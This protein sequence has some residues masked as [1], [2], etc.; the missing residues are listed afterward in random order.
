MS[1]QEAAS[2]EKTESQ[3]TQGW[4]E[5]RGHLV[6]V[7]TAGIGLIGFSCPAS[8]SHVRGVSRVMFEGRTKEKYVTCILSPQNNLHCHCSY[9]CFVLVLPVPVVRADVGLSASGIC[10]GPSHAW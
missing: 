10:G 6:P 1:I 9:N 3:A 8:L 5:T 2:E 4:K 7:G